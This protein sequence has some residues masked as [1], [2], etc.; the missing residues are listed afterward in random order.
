LQFDEVWWRAEIK[1][2][3]WMRNIVEKKNVLHAD[4]RVDDR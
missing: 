1:L 2:K 4:N 3:R